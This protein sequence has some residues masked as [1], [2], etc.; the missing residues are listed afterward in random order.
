MSLNE[1][2][3]EQPETMESVLKRLDDLENEVRT[4]KKRIRNSRALNALL[5]A[6][7][8]LFLISGEFHFGDKWSGNVRSRDLPL[9][10]IISAFA[11]GAS[12]LGVIGFEDLV[13]LLSRKSS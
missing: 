5:A 11:I 2:P 8:P 1:L 10:D 6:C 9:G 3:Q 12:A 13:K 4:N 7:I